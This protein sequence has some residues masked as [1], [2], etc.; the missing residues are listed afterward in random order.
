MYLTGRHRGNREEFKLEGHAEMN[1]R[2]EQAVPP[3]L[4]NGSFARRITSTELLVLGSGILMILALTYFSLPRYIPWSDEMQ[5]VDPGAS[6][7]F[8]HGFT[9][10]VF[11]FQRPDEFFYG[12]AP[13]FSFLLAP[14]FGIFGFG[15]LQARG[16]SV[17]CSILGLLCLW[18]FLVRSAPTMPG[19]LRALACV[20]AFSGFGITINVWTARYDALGIL[21][22]CAIALA[23]TYGEQRKAKLGLFL[24]G[25]LSFVAGFQLVFL[26]GAISALVLLIF[27][28]EATRRLTFL[29]AGVATGAAIWFGL[30]L[31]FGSLKKFFM[32]ML[33]SQLSITGQLGQLIV[34]G[35]RSLL[36]RL[37]QW[38][39]MLMQD[40]S[41]V[42]MASLMIALLFVTGARRA[43]STNPV[44]RRLALVAFW[45][46]VVVPAVIFLSHAFP[47]YYSWMAYV[48]V[49]VVAAFLADLPEGNPKIAALLSY[50]IAAGL[51]IALGIFAQFRIVSSS[52]AG[53]AYR[54]FEKSV[55]E[56]LRPNDDVY[57]D[58]AAYF[59]ARS[60]ARQ[61]F[62]PT[63]GNTRLVPGFPEKD[64]IDLMVVNRTSLPDAKSRLGGSWEVT[65]ELG[66]GLPAGSALDLV[67]ARR[68]KDSVLSNRSD[69]VSP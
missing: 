15:A 63:Y 38:K 65:R 19:W 53:L 20:T 47:L 14:W 49:V 25:A 9:S 62:S 29:W 61:V 54:N 60:V 22:S 26:F 48:P 5:L 50:G 37:D 45:M 30:I 41:L 46:I 11:P 56:E 8:G 40:P 28:K 64:S 36:N 58:S 52:D 21:L 2:Q 6:L 17:A 31:V 1:S 32:I 66:V 10:G 39:L 23:W 27:G 16:F 67:V 33:G 57:V 59:A 7:Y 42:V 4:E 68:M 3:G 44:V 34:Q 24:A 43:V 13:G 12:N 18:L 55:R 35:D 51:A 69:K